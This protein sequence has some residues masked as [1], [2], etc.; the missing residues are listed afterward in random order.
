[1]PKKDLTLSPPAAEAGKI[2]VTETVAKERMDVEKQK[3]KLNGLAALIVV[4]SLAA[5]LILL[6]K[7]GLLGVIKKIY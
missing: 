5:D 1:M 4:G 7:K 6:K 2:P 3:G